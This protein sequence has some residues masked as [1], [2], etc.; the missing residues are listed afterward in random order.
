MNTQDLSPEWHDVAARD[1]LDPDFPMGVEVAGHNVGL[2]LLDDQVH[3]LDDICPHAFAMLSQGFQ[4]NGQIECP[5]HAARF[6]IATGKC[7]NEIGE[8]DVRCF[9]VRV[10]DGRVAVRIPIKP[11]GT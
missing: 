8:R 2:F 3:A 9:P 6:D 4:E 1:Q 11:S 5:L 10:Q 7:L